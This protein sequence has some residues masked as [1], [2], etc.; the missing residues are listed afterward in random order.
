[1]PFMF[2]PGRYLPIHYKVENE[3]LKLIESLQKAMEVSGYHPNEKGPS[4][5]NSEN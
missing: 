2:W 4:W 5:R 3:L 1:M